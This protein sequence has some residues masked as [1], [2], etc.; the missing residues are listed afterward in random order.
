MAGAKVYITAGLP[1]AKLTGQSATG[2]AS[3][4]VTAGLPINK[5]ASY[6]SISKFMNIDWTNISKISVIDKSNISKLD[7]IS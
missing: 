4:F 2:N 1:I 6:A 7:N 3:A 5:Q